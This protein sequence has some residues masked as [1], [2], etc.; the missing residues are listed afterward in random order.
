MKISYDHD[1]DTIYLQFLE[2]KIVESEEIQKDVI[3]DYNQ[4]N[5][6]VAIEILHAKK[7][8]ITIDI[9]TILKSA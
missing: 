7:E 5:E 6:I 4:Q 3:V 9:P 8:S 2:D 1:S